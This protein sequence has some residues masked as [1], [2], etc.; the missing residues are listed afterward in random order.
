MPHL[1]LPTPAP[2]I[3]V[4]FVV[5]QDVAAPWTSYAWSSVRPDAPARGLLLHAAGPT[6][7]GYRTIDVWVSRRC[8]REHGGTGGA[9][10]PPGLVV[11]PTVRDLVV[12][13][14]VTASVDPP[15]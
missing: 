7:E 2:D 4:G 8:A 12:L 3:P 9:T 10:R 5:V 11:P 14:L 15:R 1:H 6:D 13:R